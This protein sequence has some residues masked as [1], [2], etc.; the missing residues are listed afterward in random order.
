MVEAE[1]PQLAGAHA[2]EPEGRD[3]RVP[4]AAPQTVQRRGVVEDLGDLG[5]GVDRHL[6]RGDARGA[7]M[8]GRIG[9][10]PTREDEPGVEPAQ[11]R[12]LRLAGGCA[13]AAIGLGDEE[14]REVGRRRLRGWQA[15]TRALPPGGERPHHEV[16]VA[17]GLG[18]EPADRPLVVEEV[19]DQPCPRRVRVPVHAC[20]GC[21]PWGSTPARGGV[22]CGRRR[23]RRRSG[24]LPAVVPAQPR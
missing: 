6:G 17:E 8:D 22:A 13:H 20:D 1:G 11:R 16:A 7:E 19:A 12:R 23:R 9:A 24:V 14:R 3:D 5:R 4:D 15:R 18:R 21:R 2:G 10:A